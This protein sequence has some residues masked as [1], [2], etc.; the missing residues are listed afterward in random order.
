MTTASISVEK[1]AAPEGTL[2]AIKIGCDEFEI[3]VWVREAEL[4]RLSEVRRTPWLSGSLRIGTAA[5]AA[6][7]WSVSSPDEGPPTLSILVG[8]DDETWDFGVTLPLDVLDDV[9]NAV[10]EARAT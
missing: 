10:E 8:H 3:N 7:W 5:E 2:Y 1:D 4:E 6:A 9:L